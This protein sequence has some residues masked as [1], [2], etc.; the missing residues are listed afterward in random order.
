LA[1]Q[2][3]SRNIQAGGE[4]TGVIHFH[5]QSAIRAESVGLKFSGKETCSWEETSS[6]TNSDG[7]TTSST[8]Y[9]KGKSSIVKQL[10]PIFVFQ[11]S[12][13]AAGDYSFPFQ[14]NTPATLPGSFQYELATVNAHIKYVLSGYLASTTAKVNKAKAEVGVTRRM[15]EVIVSLQETVSAQVSTMCCLR[16]G[17]VSLG[18]NIS[19]SAYVP[20]E[21]CNLTVE[22]DNSKSLLDV[23]GFKATLYRT[24][25]LR[26]NEG[27]PTIIKLAVNE[28][29]AYKRIPVKQVLSGHSAIH[30][31]LA[32]QDSKGSVQNANTVRGKNIECIYTVVVKAEMDGCCMCCGQTPEITRE[33][34]VYPMQLPVMEMPQAPVGWNPTIMP[35]AQFSTLIEEGCKPSAPPLA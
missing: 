32:V 4:I 30:M 16:K 34:T 18:A 26:S 13:V 10:F 35:L 12:Q 29:S 9:Y 1:V 5:V 27:A 19:K 21:I 7:S 8:T 11:D 22:L 20:G 3:E 31:S 28:G 33:V 17:V 25:R 6:S 14:I 24:I 23:L 15:T 2:V